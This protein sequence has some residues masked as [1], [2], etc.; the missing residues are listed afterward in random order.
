MWPWKNEATK[1]CGDYYL[2]QCGAGPGAAA[3]MLRTPLARAHFEATLA[4]AQRSGRWGHQRM[5]ELALST[6]MD[7]GFA[8][9]GHT[10]PTEAEADQERALQ[11][12]G[13]K[14]RR[15]AP[16]P[17]ELP[18]D[19]QF[20]PFEALDDLQA[21]AW[22]TNSYNYPEDSEVLRVT[23]PVHTSDERTDLVW[24]EMHQ[25]LRMRLRSEVD[26]PEAIWASGDVLDFYAGLLRREVQ[27][28][29]HQP[30][31]PRLFLFPTTSYGRI[32]NARTLGP[33][34]QRHLRREMRAVRAE[35]LRPHTKL[36]FPANQTGNH[37]VVSVVVIT[38][39]GEGEIYYYDSLGDTFR[40]LYH[41]NLQ[42]WLQLERAELLGVPSAPFRLRMV[43]LPDAD[44]AAVFRQ[45]NIYDCGV[46]AMMVMR[47]VT[48]R[49]IYAGGA[50]LIPRVLSLDRKQISARSDYMRR[51]LLLEMVNQRIPFFDWNIKQP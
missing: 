30:G 15:P 5:C 12:A 20:P 31:E 14:R 51:L 6:A 45:E 22:T 36:V 11:A 26:E 40:P 42:E 4:E 41:R 48:L 23:V 7:I 24:L 33:E 29:S 46:F 35:M 1:K 38:G 44:H 32:E 13:C 43:D 27:R 9:G 37:W 17:N 34:Q 3:A 8:T 28:R 49:H 10:I 21:R 50:R 18:A 2:G 16:V 39:E 25:M 47:G 19:P